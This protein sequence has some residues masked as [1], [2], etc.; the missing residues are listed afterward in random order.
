METKTLLDAAVE[1]AVADVKRAE[2][3]RVEALR[4]ADEA[5]AVLR[6]CRRRLEDIRQGK[7]TEEALRRFVAGRT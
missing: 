1:A 3:K 6:L 2:N 4:K 7:W 5:S